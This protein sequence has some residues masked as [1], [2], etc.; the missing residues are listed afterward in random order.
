MWWRKCAKLPGLQATRLT[1]P[2]EWQQRQDFSRQGLTNNWLWRELDTGVCMD[3]VRS[4]RRT[5]NEQRQTLSDVVSL[6]TL[7]KQ[8]SRKCP[9]DV[10]IHFQLYQLIHT[11]PVSFVCL[12]RH[13]DHRSFWP[14]DHEIPAGIG[15]STPTPTSNWCRLTTTPIPTWS[16]GFQ[17]WCRGEMWQ[18]A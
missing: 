10:H 3:G 14:G 7:Q 6:V 9:W 4:Y 11:L 8:R 17:W 18:E 13:R 12:G 5:S 2:Y 15:P 1:T 16:R